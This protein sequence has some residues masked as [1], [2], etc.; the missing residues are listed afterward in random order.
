M[1]H[2]AIVERNVSRGK[3]HDT[4]KQ[5]SILPPYGVLALIAI[6]LQIEKRMK[7]IEARSERVF[8]LDFQSRRDVN[9]ELGNA[10]KAC[11]SERK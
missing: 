1:A 7:V 10:E 5:R 6:F 4:I 3:S 2:H 11:A 8:W 9:I